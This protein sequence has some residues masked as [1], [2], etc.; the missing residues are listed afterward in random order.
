V[1]FSPEEGRLLTGV[2]AERVG[3]M[4]DLGTDEELRSRYVIDNAHGSQIG[5]ASLRFHED[6]LVVLVLKEDRTQEKSEPLKE[7]SALFSTLAPSASTLI[8][9]GHIYLLRVV[10]AKDR[11]RQLFVKLMVIAYN[12]KESVTLRWQQI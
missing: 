7:A 6:K 5:F 4:V 10:D 12:P 9:L 11:T 1:S 8:A 2:E 3:A